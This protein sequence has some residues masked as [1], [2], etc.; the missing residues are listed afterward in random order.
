M[1]STYI[2]LFLI[3]LIC[4]IRMAEHM[5]LL[6]ADYCEHLVFHP[7]CGVT[8]AVSV[9]QHVPQFKDKV[10]SWPSSLIRHMIGKFQP[11]NAVLPCGI[12]VMDNLVG[13]LHHFTCVIYS[14]NSAYL[15]ARPYLVVHY[16]VSIHKDCQTLHRWTLTSGMWV[17]TWDTTFICSISEIIEEFQSFQTIQSGK[18]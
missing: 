14:I 15:R 10:R 13:M 17:T 2:L 8:R 11:F 3:D 4:P 7:G 18:P 12:L 6:G 1:G 16:F 9:L 5:E